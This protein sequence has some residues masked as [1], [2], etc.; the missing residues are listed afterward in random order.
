MQIVFI[1]LS[2]KMSFAYFAT[3]HRQWMK[4][5]FILPTGIKLIHENN[6]CCTNE[7]SP[8]KVRKSVCQAFI[9]HS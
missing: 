6:S 7:Q 2:R 1:R 3:G 4:I 8:K 5:K 9:I